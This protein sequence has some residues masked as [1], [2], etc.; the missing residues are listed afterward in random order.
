MEHILYDGQGNMVKCERDNWKKCPEHKFFTD[1][2]SE[3]LTEKIQNISEGIEDR[4]KPPFVI[5]IE[6]LDGARMLLDTDGQ[7]YW[8]QYDSY[9]AGVGSSKIGW[10]GKI[11]YNRKIKDAIAKAWAEEDKRNKVMEQF[12]DGQG[13]HL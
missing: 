7:L 11:G 1:K 6:D 2:M 8:K 10:I 3:E 5:I 9:G 4:S 13:F 12:D